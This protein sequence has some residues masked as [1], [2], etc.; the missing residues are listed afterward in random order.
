MQKKN[1]FLIG[2]GV[3]VLGFLALWFYTRQFEEQATGGKK[4]DIVVVNQTLISGTVLLASHLGKQERPVSYVD[5]RMISG[6]DL[7]K[8]I[9]APV[10]TRIEAGQPLLWSDLSAD[11]RRNL[12]SLVL[13]G[14][15]AMTINVDGASSFSGLLEPGDRVDILYTE[16]VE[17]GDDQGHRT[18]TLLQ[19]LL[20]LATGNNTGGVSKLDAK[21]DRVGQVTL[22]VTPKEAQVL[23]IAEE[24]GSLALSL[25]NPDDIINVEGL[26]VT[27]NE[28]LPISV[29]R[30]SP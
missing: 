8:I 25:R 11:N 15:R 22:A 6:A 5:T 1:A 9:G 3:S 20:V 28:D 13:N 21:K 27:R 24:R 17:V 30:A 10:M 12:S 18:S 2:L 29:G 19:N 4:V 7:Q 16:E 14:K 26:P 23:T